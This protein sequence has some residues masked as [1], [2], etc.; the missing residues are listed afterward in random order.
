MKSVSTNGEITYRETTWHND[1]SGLFSTPLVQTLNPTSKEQLIGNIEFFMTELANYR[2][3]ESLTSLDNA[4]A[5]AKQ[6]GIDTSEFE[7][8][9]P[10]IL[11]KIQK[12]ELTDIIKPTKNI[13]KP[14]EDILGSSKFKF[15]WIWT[16]IVDEHI[17]QPAIY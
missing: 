8:K 5:I 12:F 4:I 13:F 6:Q 2:N 1:L 16:R 10:E 3:M 17:T 14:L 11:K 15:W 7:N 9:I